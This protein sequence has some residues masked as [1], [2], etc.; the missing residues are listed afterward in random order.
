MN[1][2]PLFVHFPIALLCIYSLLELIRFKKVLSRGYLFYTK[3]ILVILGTVGAVAAL[4]T[5]SIAEDIYQGPLPQ[6]IP[7]PQGNPLCPG[8][9][10]R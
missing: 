7:L 10:R 1:I 9:G 6:G 2:H 5:G 4:F 8:Q 3:A